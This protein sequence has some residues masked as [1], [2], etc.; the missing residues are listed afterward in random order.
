MLNAG[1]SGDI[2][3]LNKSELPMT[4]EFNKMAEEIVRLTTGKPSCSGPS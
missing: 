3:F 2:D 4:R 1:D